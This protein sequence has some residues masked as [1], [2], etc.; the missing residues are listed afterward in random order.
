MVLSLIHIPSHFIFHILVKLHTRAGQRLCHI[1]HF[2]FFSGWQPNYLIPF[3]RTSRHS[4]RPAHAS[5]PT[6][7]RR[8]L[9]FFA[10]NITKNTYGKVEKSEL[11]L[12]L[13]ADILL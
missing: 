7:S 11:I 1:W 8:E 9:P 5:L 12:R 6:S 13:R 4:N 10:G 3:S 2:I